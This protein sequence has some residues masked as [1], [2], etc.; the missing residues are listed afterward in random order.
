M[1]GWM[2]AIRLYVRMMHVNNNFINSAQSTKGGRSSNNAN[3]Q[4][5]R[6]MCMYEICYGVYRILMDTLL[7]SYFAV[8][9][10]GKHTLLIC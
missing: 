8:V 3:Q 6:M 9:V 10:L 1:D 4:H 7:M 5:V 2:Y